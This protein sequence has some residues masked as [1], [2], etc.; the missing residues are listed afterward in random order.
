MDGQMDRRT[1][2]WMEGQMEQSIPILQYPIQLLLMGIKTATPMQINGCSYLYHM[3][4]W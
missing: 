3:L 2:G 1:D 4:T